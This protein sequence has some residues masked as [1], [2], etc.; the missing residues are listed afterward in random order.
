MDFVKFWKLVDRYPWIPRILE[1]TSDWNALM[2]GI[3][4]PKGAHMMPN[5]IG[6]LYGPRAIAEKIKYIAVRPWRQLDMNQTREQDQDNRN[7]EGVNVYA[8]GELYTVCYFHSS[9]RKEFPFTNSI[10]NSSRSKPEHSLDLKKSTGDLINQVRAAGLIL[11]AVV[12]VRN[13]QT[14][15]QGTGDSLIENVTAFLKMT[16]ES[17]TYDIFLPPK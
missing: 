6:E 17:F 9:K 2:E 8:Y 12:V 7:I 16:N 1:G 10:N 5:I 11:D 14:V 3:A 15:G 4:P 13:A